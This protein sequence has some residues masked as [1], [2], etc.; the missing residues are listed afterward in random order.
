[1]RFLGETGLGGVLA[2]DMGLGKTVQTLAHILAEKLDGRRQA[3]PGR[4][5]HI[6]DGQLADR[7]G[8]FRAGTEVAHVAWPDRKARFDAVPGH[9]LVLTTYALL[10]ARP[11][12]S[13]GPAVARGDRRRGTE[14]QEPGHQRR[15]HPAPARSSPTFLPLR[16]A[17]REPPRR[18]VGADGFPRSGSA[19][20]PPAFRA[21]LP[22]ADREERRRRP[23]AGSRQRVRPFLLRRTK[24]QVAPELPPKTEII[25][26]VEMEA[27]QSAIY[28]AVRLTMHR[29][30]REAITARASTAAASS[31]SMRS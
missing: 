14:R 1:M 25:E 7:S 20:R 28:E 2:D 27:G 6:A 11:R 19:Q 18:A 30:V 8:A 23:S 4:R 15:A 10:A 5:P 21:G 24:A 31:S 29:K 22:C 3:E 13:A 26:H 9:D 17:G 16:N 12:R